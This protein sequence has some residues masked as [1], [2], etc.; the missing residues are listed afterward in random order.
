MDEIYRENVISKENYRLPYGVFVGSRKDDDAEIPVRVFS[1][2]GW[3]LF[4]KE[5]KYPAGAWATIFTLSAAMQYQYR[6][7]TLEKEG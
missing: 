5:M 3:Y 6:E 7:F 1:P 2:A 4:H